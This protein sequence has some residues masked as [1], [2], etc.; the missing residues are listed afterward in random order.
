MPFKTFDVWDQ[1]RLTDEIKRPLDGRAPGAAEDASSRL[2]DV[3]APLTPTY[4]TVCK[5]NVREIK[6]FGIGQFRAW[7]ASVPLFKPEVTWSETLMELVLVDEQERIKELE[8][9]KLNSPN[10]EERRSAGLDLISRG[11]V[12]R[13]SEEHTSELQSPPDLVCR[14]L[15]EKKKK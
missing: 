9:K 6:P 14:L 10:E 11:R 13:R 5:V 8:W 12:L 1:A 4:E 15:L 2:G 3:I 7:D